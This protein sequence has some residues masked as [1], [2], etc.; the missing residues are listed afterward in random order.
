MRASRI[1]K[2]GRR[3]KGI[4]VFFALALILQLI[5]QVTTSSESHAAINGVTLSKTATKSEVAV[6]EEFLYVIE[7]QVDGATYPGGPVLVEDTVPPQFEILEEDS[8]SDG[9]WQNGGWLQKSG[10]K[11]TFG[12]QNVQSGTAY[13]LEIPVRAKATGLAVPVNTTNT[14]TLTS[15]N[16]GQSVD[17]TADVTIKADPNPDPGS[18]N[19]GGGTDVVHSTWEV[20]K[21]QDTGFGNT[22]IVGGR[23]K[24][25]VGLEPNDCTKEC[26]NLFNA[27]L[28]DTLPAGAIP[29]QSTIK[30]GGVYNPAEGTITW[31][32]AELATGTSFWTSYEV[33]FPAGLGHGISP[34]TPLTRVNKVE[35]VSHDPFTMGGSIVDDEDEVTT[36]FNQ[37]VTGTP[38]LSK[39]RGFVYRYPGQSQTYTIDGIS[40]TG[41]G[42][43][44]KLTNLVL[45]D[46]LPPEMDFSKIRMP[47]R[48]VSEFLY[49]KN[50]GAWI[51]FGTNINANREITVGGAGSEIALGAGEFLTGLQ[52]KFNELPAGSTISN[53]HLVGTVRAN[54]HGAN[55]P[56]LHGTVVTNTVNLTYDA[57]NASG[58]PQPQ[59]PINKQVEF[60]INNPKPWL[61]AEKSVGSGNFM[62]LS[63]VPFTLTIR[64][65]KKATGNYVNP[66]VYDLLPLNF[67]FVTDSDSL[68]NVTNPSP[69]TQNITK[70]DLE[71]TPNFNGTGRTLLTWTWPTTT[72]VEFI[73]DSSFQIT[74]KAVIQAGTPRSGNGVTYT[75]DMYITTQNPQTTFWH[76]GS[77]TPAPDDPETFASWAQKP[78]N[79]S[80]KDH[81][82]GFKPTSGTDQY[83]V[84][85]SE[86]VTV[87]K[88]SFVQSTKWNRGDLPAVERDDVDGSYDPAP[89]IPVLPFN[90]DGPIQYTEYPYYSVTFEGGTADYRLAIRNSG[91]TRLGKID[92]IDI[93][94]HVGDNAVRVS[95]SSYEA[96]GTQ[97]RPNLSEVIKSGQKTFTSSA[98]TG[99]KTVKFDVASYVSKS[100]DQDNVVNFSN[101]TGA[102]TGWISESSFTSDDLSDIYSLYFELTN[103]VGSDGLPGMAPGDYIV[104]DW[105]MDAPVGAE[106]GKVAWNS[107]AIQATEAGTD[108]SGE[109]SKM[110]PTAPNKV[111]F[112]IDPNSVHKTLGEIGNFV[113]FDSNRNGL[114]DEEYDGDG[115][116]AAGINGI[117]V[118][119]YKA[120][121]LNTIIRSSKTGYNTEGKPGYYLFQ[122][123]ELDKDYVVE[124]VLPKQ[125]EPTI[126]NVKSANPMIVEADPTHTN[127]ND[128]NRVGTGISLSG[129]YTAYRTDAISLTTTNKKNHT[130]DFGIVEE[131]TTPPTDYPSIEMEKKITSVAQGTSAKQ[132]TSNDYA[133]K[134]NI[135]NYSIEVKNTSSVTLHNIKVSDVLDR[136]QSGFTFNTLEYGG[137]SIAI[138]GNTHNR[139]DVISGINNAGVNPT[140]FIKSLGANES[141]VLKGSY[142]VVAADVD[143]TNLKNTVTLN[144]NESP[145]TLTDD[146]EIPLAGLKVEKTGS[147][148]QVPHGATSFFIDYTVTIEN[149]G[150]YDLTNLVINDTKVPGIPTI[151]LLAVGEVKK[152]TY[153]YE[154]TTATMPAVGSNVTNTVTVTPDETPGETD[155]HDIPVVDTPVGSIGDYV[156]LDANEDGIQDAGERGINGITVKLYRDKAGTPIA[157]TVTR[158]NEGKDGY[159]LFP[160]LP[161]DTYY[162]KFEVPNDYAVT[163]A[164]AAA[165]TKETDSN[166]TDNDGFTE[167]IDI[168]PGPAVWD[169]PTIDLG[170]VP[171]GEIGNYVWLDRNRDGIQNENEKDGINGIEVR[172]HKDNKTGTPIATTTTATKDGKPG[173]Y[174]F[175]NL[176]AGSYYVEFVIPVDY[177]KTVQGVGADRAV[178]SNVTTTDG[179]SE[180]TD[181]INIG[182]APG[183][184]EW[185][186]H[187]IDLGL[188]AKG[189]IGNYVWLDANVNGKQ[190]E[191]P[192][193][194]V[195]GITVKLYDKDKNLLAETL[196]GNDAGG[197]PGYYLFEHLV[198]GDYYVNFTVPYGYLLTIAEASGVSADLD[199]NK[200]TN[201]FTS[202]ITIG[203][204]PGKV[205]EDLTIDLG[206]NYMPYIPPVKPEP[207]P[208]KPEP[209]KPEPEKPEPEK[210]DPEKPEPEKP[211]PEKP[212]DPIK[213]VTE[214]DKPKE[215][216]VDVPNGGKPSVGEKPKHGTVTVDKD[217]KWK[218]VPKPGFK[219]KDSFSI[220]VVDKDGNEQEIFYEIDV[221]DVPLGGIDV[222]GGIGKLPKTG[223]SSSLPWQLLGI[224]LIVAAVALRAKRLR[225]K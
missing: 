60:Y 191:Q 96:R 117:T 222:P 118:N 181:V 67:E 219:G 126:A 57:P 49:K 194:G 54:A 185:I 14:V 53:A 123:L 1:S 70:P 186:D 109:G 145:E 221:E 47:N 125:Y 196:T 139:P 129:D 146:E 9:G 59:T 2:F 184:P 141:F 103:I 131:E 85:D 149:I 8:N 30:N 38:N 73:P 130:I 190:D 166:A 32:I 164:E 154:V 20:I 29:D 136:N 35:L 15:T 208:E 102:K 64:N 21:S 216:E 218:Y 133:V 72:T 171:R 112:V 62:P 81:A 22:P 180:F 65:D 163:K 19:P 148:L 193:Y 36:K 140:I 151:P 150:N 78:Y 95:G 51:S 212:T 192:H 11:L 213:E 160:G 77:S 42:V 206:L 87:R 201:G 104:L 105:K 200:L 25:T 172:L 121:D 5:G 63:E 188:V 34:N 127:D 178:D 132:P 23:V 24:Y 223:E 66:V 74:Y 177:S 174:L 189:A 97:W 107:F 134:G 138:N 75:N 217:G 119:L 76:N 187:T 169:D 80:Q 37:P 39:K 46:T 198:A 12:P 155:D 48:A 170:L 10:Q 128:S 144:Y 68:G 61:V 110:L 225:R 165:A 159:Y 175:D 199:S 211:D 101:V 13:R 79:A 182:G 220:I 215:G 91:N 176:L 26:E 205:W 86:V 93:L 18:G 40:N 135:V 143:G 88:A 99:G 83:F 168:G 44:S 115:N 224:A 7:F 161:A 173:Y 17:D 108:G 147:A 71:I 69:G 214:K 28:V 210:P 94:P 50:T 82:L 122:G 41:N 142:E 157:Q 152:I 204:G 203:D 158:T 114:Q 113:W 183:A 90:P 55:D 209:E 4:L 31:T 167:A 106:V 137:D 202:L 179:T 98:A 207:E 197:N 27:K 153:T 162:V 116:Q 58:T 120:N 195:N 45:T 43:N 84:Y 92:V 33:D 3:K 124:F 111:G 6:G 56:V 100:V 16:L 52:W 156:W 89:A